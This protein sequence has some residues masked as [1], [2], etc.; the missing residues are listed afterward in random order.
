[1]KGTQTLHLCD[2]SVNEALQDYIN[3]HL[4]TGITVKVEKWETCGSGY[5]ASIEATFEQVT[6]NGETGGTTSG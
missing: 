6:G 3:K 5:T 1:M 2:A 4:A